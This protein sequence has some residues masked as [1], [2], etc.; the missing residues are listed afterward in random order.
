MI[1]PGIGFRV[2]NTRGFANT[3]NVRFA[4]LVDGMDVQSPHIGAPIGNALGPNDLDIEKVEI[5]PGI[6][7]A[8]YG[9]NTING[10]ADFTTRN[11]FTST[12]ISVQQKTAVF[13]VGNSNAST[14]I[15]SE[16]SMRIAY[17]LS[18]KVAFKLNGTFSKGK[19]W[20]AD[21]YTDLN[22]NANISTGLTGD[23]NPA[24]DPVN[25][26]GNESSNRKT[27]SLQNKSYVVARTG[28]PEV[29][30]TDYRVNNIRTDGGVYVQLKKNTA[31]NYLFRMAFLDNTY[32]R[33]N[34]FALKDYFLQQHGLQFQSKSIQAKVYINT[35]NTGNSYN[36]RSMGENIDR[37]FKPDN[38][39]YADYTN[40]YN[41]AIS[42]AANSAD[43][44]RAARNFADAGRY[45]PGTDEF[46]NALSKLQ[47]VNNWDSGA[48]LKVK[49]G[50]IHAEMQI[51]LTEN[52]LS[53]LKNAI[54]LEMLAGF[55]H[56]TYSVY[57]DGNYFINPE[58]GKEN[59]NIYYSKTGGFLSLS[60]N[61]VDNKLRLGFILRADKNDYF[62]LLF[63]PRFTASYTPV[64]EQNIRF[65]FQNGY[66]YPIIFEAFSNVNSGG[67]KRVGGLP[68]MSQGI[69]ENAWLQTSISAFQSAVLKDINSNSIPRN[70]AIEKNKSLLK[71]N[72]YTYI[73]PEKVNSVELGYRG[74]FFKS[75]LYI[76]ADFYFNS[77]RSFI[78]QANMNVPMTSNPDSIPFYLY[79]NT[80]QSKYRMWTNSTTKV[81]NYGFNLGLLYRFKKGYSVNANTSY[82]R[83]ARTAAEDG[84]ED[85]FNTPEWM[86]NLT[87]SNK[88][89]IKRVGAG[90]SVRWQSGFYWQSFLV[91][92]N[93]PSFTTLDANL[94]YTFRKEQFSIK[95]GGTNLLNRYYYSLLGGPR[96]GGFYYLTINYGMN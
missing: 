36:L 84:L 50:F 13:N 45:Q 4:Q 42:N 38:T 85:G 26:Y 78:A 37:D 46:N 69:F 86:I 88:Q 52:W 65:S 66:R 41:N 12:G 92:G 77:F 22:P 14:R 40:G 94:S 56:R 21:N 63:N 3:T 5:L 6:A 61:M 32:Q 11:P 70:E 87:V 95:A 33:S 59:K 57:P 58:P 47:Q 23:D 89:I 34:R 53:Q 80:K 72:P 7:S 17:R 55:D 74:L 51:N 29:D 43:A 27:L 68:V 30:L 60:K 93:V 44:H 49:A 67:V 10:L 64:R 83:L 91:S 9:M 28:Y 18:D 96:I 19:D 31:F 62:P 54:G 2:L 35:E 24:M 48:A 81:Y 90:I 39:W 75:R 79:D 71:K 25:S 15:F 82:A 8:L 16:T 20:I 1:T 76:D 73:Q